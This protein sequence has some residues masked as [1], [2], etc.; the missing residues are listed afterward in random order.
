MD[1][2]T[3]DCTDTSQWR[4]RN[5]SCDTTAAGK[6]TRYRTR[7]GAI[8]TEDLQSVSKRSTAPLPLFCFQL[9]DLYGWNFANVFGHEHVNAKLFLYIIFC[10]QT[11]RVISV[12]PYSRSTT[13]AYGHRIF[14]MISANLCLQRQHL[15]WNRQHIVVVPYLLPGRSTAHSKFSGVSSSKAEVRLLIHHDFFFKVLIVRSLHACKRNH[16]CI[17]PHI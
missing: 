5:C 1:R 11:N 17:R 2:L 6:L 16:V 8:Q 15:G 12:R 4:C 14:F 10:G 9:I 13:F 7:T 3:T